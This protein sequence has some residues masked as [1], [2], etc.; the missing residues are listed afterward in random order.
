MFASTQKGMMS[1]A[2]AHGGRKIVADWL[3]PAHSIR[4]DQSNCALQTHVALT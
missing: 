4:D 1:Y 2:S 3:I